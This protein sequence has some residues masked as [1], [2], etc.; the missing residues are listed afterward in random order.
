MVVCSDLLVLPACVQKAERNPNTF[1]ES[2]IGDARRL[3]PVIAN[4]A[5]SGT[6]NDQIFN[7]LVKYDKDIK[8]IGDLA[9]RWEVTNS[10][11][12][13]TFYLRKGVKWHDGVE[14]TAEDCL[15]TYQRLID[16]KVATPYSSS[17]MDVLKAEVVSK[18]IFRV[19]YK[20]PFS[21]ALE[22]W[23][24]GMHPEASSGRQGH[25]HR[26]LQPESRRHRALPVQGMDRR[27]EDRARGE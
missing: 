25:Q 6:I 12:T 2:S 20:E 17:Y 10:G 8:L 3:N 11:K 23:N 4:D 24:M 19:T 14:F 18:Y 26:C 16:P 15:F 22:S 7:G 27:A 13:I 5:A 9:E 21:P 1:V